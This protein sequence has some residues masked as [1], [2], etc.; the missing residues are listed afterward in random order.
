MLTINKKIIFFYNESESGIH[1]LKKLIPIFDSNDLNLISK[2]DNNEKKYFDLLYEV[3]ER[4][5]YELSLFMKIEQFYKINY[6]LTLKKTYIFD[7]DNKLYFLYN[8][9]VNCVAY[10]SIINDQ[11]R[12]DIWDKNEKHGFNLHFTGYTIN[13][14]EDFFSHVK[15]L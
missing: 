5:P 4:S 6:Y 9:N 1:L 11:F 3:M 12:V 8:E 15:V 10:H 13:E 14:I 2:S 7:N